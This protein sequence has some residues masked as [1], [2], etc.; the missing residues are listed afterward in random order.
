M[1]YF[2]RYYVMCMFLN[3]FI[4]GCI[5]K[6]RAHLPPCDP[7]RSDEPLLV[8]VAMGPLA[9][10]MMLGYVISEERGPAW[11]RSEECR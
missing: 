10:A 7:P 3:A 5:L 9:H 11:R 2:V 8:L 4:I 1:K 6:D